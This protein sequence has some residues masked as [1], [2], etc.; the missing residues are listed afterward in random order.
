MPFNPNDS[1]WQYQSKDL[2]YNNS[3]KSVNY[4]QSIV[5]DSGFSMGNS[6]HL[7]FKKGYS[8]TAIGKLNAQ[9]VFNYKQPIK[10][11]MLGD[12]SWIYQDSSIFNSADPNGFRL[13]FP[14]HF[15]VGVS[16]E[17]GYSVNYKLSAFTYQKSFENIPGFEMDSIAKFY[18]LVYDLNDSIINSHPWSNALLSVS[19]NNG[20]IDMIDLTQLDMKLLFSKINW[21]GD[22]ISN[23]DNS[24]LNVGDEYHYSIWEEDYSTIPVI[25]KYKEHEIHINSIT[26][27]GNIKQINFQEYLLIRSYPSG[28]ITSSLTVTNKSNS[29]ISNNVFNF[30]HSGTLDDSLISV[31]WFSG[32]L[33]MNYYFQPNNPIAPYG[34]H[35]DHLNQSNDTVFGYNRLAQEEFY[36]MLGIDS[37]YKKYTNPGGIIQSQKV[38]R[39]IKK[40]SQTWGNPL[41]L[42]LGNDKLKEYKKLLVYPNPSSHKIAIQTELDFKTIEIQS[43]NG[44]MMDRISIA[45]DIDISHLPSGLYFLKLIGENQTETL[46]LIKQ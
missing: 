32:G 17:F 40:G 21:S 43:I 35:T 36:H 41:N 44:Q 10:G 2:I 18:L 6:M 22:S 46:K 13:F 31:P 9:G 15:S 12:S 28:P 34:L 45:T 4:I 20:I 30:K 1:I 24:I 16:W 3:N 42:S 14:H 19:K 27:N 38:I 8:H 7:I 25:I 33:A 23:E 5:V 37:E 29:I 39:Y 26:Y 11:K